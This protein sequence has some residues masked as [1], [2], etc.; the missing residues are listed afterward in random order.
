VT[1]FVPHFGQR[2]WLDIFIVY[3]DSLELSERCNGDG[4]HLEEKMQKL[5]EFQ[6]TGKLLHAWSPVEQDFLVC[7]NAK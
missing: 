2:R 4:R 6:W 5:E 1:F 3:S 7:S